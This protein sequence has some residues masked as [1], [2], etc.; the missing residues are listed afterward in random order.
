[1]RRRAVVADGQGVRRD[2]HT[3]HLDRLQRLDQ[4]SREL[5]PALDSL[6]WAGQLKPVLRDWQ[7]RFLDFQILHFRVHSNPILTIF[8]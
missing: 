1:M 4:L 8:S 5:R 7:F 6:L 3:H 2:C